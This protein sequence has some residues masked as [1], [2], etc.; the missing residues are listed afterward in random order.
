MGFRVLCAAAAVVA[1]VGSADAATVTHDIVFTVTDAYDLTSYFDYEIEEMVE[2]RTDL[3]GFWGFATGSSTRGILEI[4]ETVATQLTVRL[5]VAGTAVFE[6][7]DASGT[8]EAF[9]AVSGISGYKMDGLRWTGTS[10]KLEY[11]YDG[12]PDFTFADATI[13]L[14]PIPLPAT[15]ALLPMGIGALAWM[16]KRRRLADRPLG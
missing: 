12:S 1:G 14:A 9:Y 6:A 13:S 10:G 7:D 11:T 16:R 2:V 8:I 3:P 5:V 4:V 15:A